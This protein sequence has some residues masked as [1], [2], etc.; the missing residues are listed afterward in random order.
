MGEH[1]VSALCAVMPED[2]R[3]WVCTQEN[4]SRGSERKSPSQPGP[5]I[6]G[7]V[8]LLE[9]RVQRRAADTVNRLCKG[10]SFAQSGREIVV[11][12]H[13]PCSSPLDK[14]SVVSEGTGIIETWEAHLLTGIQYRLRGWITLSGRASILVP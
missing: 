4:Q 5:N 14:R 1:F 11:R 13:S 8:A 9:C 7:V 10:T 3:E 2:L 6:L 12:Q